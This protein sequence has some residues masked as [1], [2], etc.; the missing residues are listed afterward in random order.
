LS[1]HARSE[2]SSDRCSRRPSLDE[3]HRPGLRAEPRCALERLTRMR[4]GGAPTVALAALL[5][6]GCG[7]PGSGATGDPSGVA[8]RV[9]LG[10]QCPVE[11]E[12][13]PCADKPAA[14]AKVTVA[15][16]VPGDSSAGGDVVARTTTDADGSYRVEVAPGRYVV[17]AD[18]GMSCELVGARVKAGAFSKVDIPCDTGIR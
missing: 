3:P 7:D 9:H 18:A 13:D 8:G 17:T 14:G 5:L 1:G 16:Q 11:T 10:P 12:S 6:A 2:G 15:E 4:I